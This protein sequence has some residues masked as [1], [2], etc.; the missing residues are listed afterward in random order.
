[1]T[2]LRG[3]Q[4]SHPSRSTRKAPQRVDPASPI[5]ASR[6]TEKS[7][8]E[9]PGAHAKP[10]RRPA[11]HGLQRQTRRTAHPIGYT[12]SK[13]VCRLRQRSIGR[14]AFAGGA[15]GEDRGLGR[16]CSRRRRIEPKSMRGREPVRTGPARSLPT[17][18]WDRAESG[19]WHAWSWPLKQGPGSSG[20]AVRRDASH[21]ALC[22]D[23]RARLRAVQSAS[24][25]VL[26]SLP[27]SLRRRGER[28][29]QWLSLDG[30]LCIL[31]EGSRSH[32]SENEGDSS[33]SSRA[34]VT[35]VRDTTRTR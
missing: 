3:T 8:L 32:P 34:N 22:G 14:S 6:S 27:P 20:P 17:L 12:S 24:E 33:W 9:A 2:Q 16:S 7:A 26:V 15:L 21:P 4:R 23:Q 11:G 5:A 30:S 31:H 10:T 13:V 1:M 28:C 35:L 29:L 25:V 18:G 19:A